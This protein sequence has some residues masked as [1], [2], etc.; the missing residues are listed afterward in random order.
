MT[1]T[2]F[3][4]GMTCGGCANAVT[5]V[6]KK[7]DGVT[8]I[9]TNVE[10]KSVVVTHDDSVKPEFMLEKLQKWSNASGKSVALAA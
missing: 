4:V 7:I 6:L 9:V 2:K 10:A 3:D 8:D 1:E 5:R